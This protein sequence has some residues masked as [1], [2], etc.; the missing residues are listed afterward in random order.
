MNH[1]TGKSFKLDA[2]DMSKMQ[3]M[4]AE[5]LDMERGQKKAETGLDH[6]ERNDFIIQKQENEKKRLEAEKRRILEEKDEAE[7]QTLMAMEEKDEAEKEAQ[8]AKSELTR[9]ESEASI[10]RTEIDNLEHS[11]D[12]KNRKVEQL[13]KDANE[14]RRNLFNLN[15]RK[16]WTVQALY[17]VST[18]LIAIDDSIKHCVKA[19]MDYAYSGSGG[20]GGHHGDIFYDEESSTIKR[21]MKTMSQ[22]A[23]VTMQTIGDWL[24]WIAN[25]VGH[26]NDREL[27]R[28]ETEVKDIADGN[29]DGRIQKFENGNGLS[30]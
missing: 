8:I 22:I 28:A 7:T 10:K 6:L 29:Y 16:D 14:Q 1:E 11:I 9:I 18:Y 26:F 19:I 3:D 12:I 4:V 20:R 5:A 2:E 25:V 17:A 30:R 21:V 24:V 15:N 27:H 23:N 13:T